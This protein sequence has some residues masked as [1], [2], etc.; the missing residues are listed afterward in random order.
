MRKAYGFCFS[1]GLSDRMSLEKN[2]RYVPYEV[3]IQQGAHIQLL[4]FDT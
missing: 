4:A 1:I 3:D 2:V